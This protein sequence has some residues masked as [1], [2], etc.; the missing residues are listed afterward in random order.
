MPF[1]K[2]DGDELLVAQNFVY[3]SE[4]ELRSET[5]ADHTYPVDG[6]YWF[7]TLDAAMARMPKNVSSVTMRQARLA[8]LGAGLLDD[9]DAAINA[10]PEPQRTAARINWDYSSTVERDNEVLVALAASLGLEESDL[11]NLF[12]TAASL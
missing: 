3:N 10:M 2:K 5:H 11:D 12:T 4:F 1:Y 7:D 6:W 9:V 8:L